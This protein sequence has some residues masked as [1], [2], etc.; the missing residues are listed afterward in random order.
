MPPP[1]LVIDDP[2][3]SGFTADDA[4][5]TSPIRDPT[6]TTATAEAGSTTPLPKREKRSR[7]GSDE[8]LSPD[9]WGDESVITPRN[10]N[11]ARTDFEAEGA[12]AMA[13][14][15]ASE[16]VV[17]DLEVAEI[18]ESSSNGSPGVAE[19]ASPTPNSMSI[20]GHTID[21]ALGAT[22]FEV[23]WTQV[24]GEGEDFWFERE[25][26]MD[27]HADAVLAYEAAKGL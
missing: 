18:V 24:D 11:A 10:A 13:T 14:P 26:L 17:E 8:P 6:P 25:E 4:A 9:R 5:V 21:D 15:S 1:A 27:N 3:A 7:H 22:Q 20:I 2:T 23:R 16:A 19:I 12:T